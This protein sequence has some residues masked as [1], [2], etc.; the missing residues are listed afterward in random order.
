[1][2]GAVATTPYHM[3]VPAFF[4]APGLAI[5]AALHR[6]FG[7]T[8][9]GA[10]IL[11]IVLALLS[12][13]VLALSRFTPRRVGSVVAATAAA[14]ALAWSGYGEI[15]FARSSHD[16]GDSLLANVPRPVDWVDRSVPSGTQVYYLGQSV[17]DASD[18]LQL[19]FWN[20]T[21]QHIWTTDDTAPGPGPTGVPSVVYGDGR[22][23]PARAVSVVC[24][25]SFKVVS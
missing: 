12:I 7:L 5:L 9:G 24:G 13:G 3:D 23:E 17:D 2:P 15:S 8:A 4:D 1:M 6:T 19:E 10:K 16:V 11:L 22:L 21:L 14:V 25:S 20:R 18:L